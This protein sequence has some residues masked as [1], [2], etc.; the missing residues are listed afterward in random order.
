MAVLA[1]KQK[2]VLVT[3]GTTGIGRAICSTLHRAGYEVFGTGRSVET[4]SRP[5]GYTLVR[6]DVRDADSIS[7]ALDYVRRTAGRID[8]LVNN[9][10]VGM[11]GSI[12][13]SNIEEIAEVFDVNVYGILRMCQAVLPEMRRRKNGII[14]NVSSVGAL[15]GLPYRGVYSASKAAV[16]SIT[17]S[18]SQEAMRFGVRMVLIEPGDFRTS[19]NKHRKVSAT[20]RT[21]VYGEEFERIYRLI[22]EEVVNGADPK[23][24]GELVHRIIRSRRPRLRYNVGN[25]TS[26]AA[27]WLKFILPDR[28]FEAIMMAHYGMGRKPPVTGNRT[29]VPMETQ[30]PASGVLHS[31]RFR[32]RT[33][34]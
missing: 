13:D 9:A 30:G 31:N 6:I 33:R 22:E 28:L 29:R 23:I 19:I 15:M 10:G 1:S 27:V 18:L 21:S 25:L 7:A 20:A 3:G 14:I 16:E 24:I 32:R 17:E 34:P 2:T 12:E 26:K 5:E 8:V 11:A 4:G